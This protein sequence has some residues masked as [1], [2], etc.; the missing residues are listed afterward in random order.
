M[1]PG[2]HMAT[3]FQPINGQELLEAIVKDFRDCLSRDTRFATH[4]AYVK[5]AYAVAVNVNVYP[6]DGG[7]LEIRR[8]T[9][10]GPSPDGRVPALPEYPDAGDPGRFTEGH[11]ATP[12]RV[13]SA[14]D[15]ALETA[16]YREGPA[17]RA[18]AREA[19]ASD[20]VASLRAEMDSMRALLKSLAGGRVTE[21]AAAHEPDEEGG[22]AA[23]VGRGHQPARASRAIDAKPTPGADVP[24]GIRGTVGPAPEGAPTAEYIQKA[25]E[26]DR[27]ELERAR[28]A[29]LATSRVV[30]NPE[31]LRRE[32]GIADKK[33]RRGGRPAAD[34][35][36]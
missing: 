13:A 12:H 24:D 20:E 23:L 33:P 2:G 18:A 30:E 3:D 15:A 21:P 22:E 1:A 5:A 17:K 36:L 16:G 11:F 29:G 6:E 8:Q 34:T 10:V 9:R 4:L 32:L 14:D 26:E 35:E 27:A 7:G 31:A 28:Q 25:E 19:G